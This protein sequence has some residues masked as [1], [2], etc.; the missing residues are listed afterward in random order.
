MMSPELNGL[1]PGLRSMIEKQPQIRLSTQASLNA[2]TSGPSSAHMIAGLVSMDRPWS[3]YSGNTTRSMVGRLRRALPTMA[4]MRWVWAARWSGVA[5]TG[6]CNCT[7]PITT[8][9]GVLFKPP[10][11]LIEA[12]P[13]FGDTEFARN[14]AHRLFRPGRRDHDQERENVGRGIEEIIALGD[15]DRL[16]RRSDGAGGAEQQRRDHALQRLP[17]RKDD[18]RH[19]HQALPGRYPLV[20]R[21][22]IIERQE[23]AADAGQTSAGRGGEKAHQI[24]RY[25]HGTGGRRA[26]AGHAH[27]QPPFGVG[28]RPR[29]DDGDDDADDQQPIDLKRRGDLRTAGPRT[30]RK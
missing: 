5:T 25:A 15:A 21:T 18:E 11:A 6:S 24:D 12:L 22:R 17:A 26:V 4:T 19:R 2:A 20:P 1:P 13:S 30:E 14:V 28:E 27:D 16:Q 9:F 29:H 10:S 8:P 23:G 7:T 3:A